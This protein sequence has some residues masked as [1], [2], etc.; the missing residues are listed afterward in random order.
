MIDEIVPSYCVFFNRVYVYTVYGTFLWNVQRYYIIPIALYYSPVLVY[1]CPQVLFA[2]DRGDCNILLCAACY[3]RLKYV[4]YSPSTL[5]PRHPPSKISVYSSTA[6][7]HSIK[8]DLISVLECR[9]GNCLSSFNQVNG[10]AR[11]WIF[12]DHT[13]SMRLHGHFQ[14]GACR[15]IYSY[16]LCVP[17]LY[18]CI[19]IL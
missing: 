15:P 1:A 6:V 9:L 10:A 17:V 12:N 5:H 16:I 4:S 2:F 13:R 8:K 18:T 14:A 11:P 7:K 19:C 3:F